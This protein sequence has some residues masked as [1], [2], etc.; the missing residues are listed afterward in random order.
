MLFQDI[1]GCVGGGLGLL[2][3]ITLVDVAA[4]GSIDSGITII[5]LW[6]PSALKRADRVDAR[7]HDPI[8]RASRDEVASIRQTVVPIRFALVEVY[9]DKSSRV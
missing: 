9:T 4:A 5:A 2:A 7:L 1:V 8:C 3:H 6:T